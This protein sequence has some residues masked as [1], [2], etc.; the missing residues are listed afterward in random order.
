VRVNNTEVG[1]A[2]EDFADTTEEVAGEGAADTTEEVAGEGAAD[3]TEDS[4][5]GSDSS[6]SSG[7]VLVARTTSDPASASPPNPSAY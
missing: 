3:T 4:S 6:E 7:S 2:A 1:A 5:S